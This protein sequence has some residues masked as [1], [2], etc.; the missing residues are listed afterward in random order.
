MSAWS[1]GEAGLWAAAM[2]Y[3]LVRRYGHWTA[4]RRWAHEEGD[5]DGGPVGNRCCPRG[6]ITTPE[7]TL[8]RVVAALC[9]WRGRLESLAGWFE[10]YPLE[11]ADVGGRRIPW[12]RAARH[13]I[14]QVTD[15]TGCGSG[16]HGH[17]CQALT[18]FLSRRGIAPDTAQGLNDQS[19]GGRFLSWNDPDRA[20][21]EGIAERLALSLR[22]D[23]GTRSAEPTPD[24]PE[25]W[26][27]VREAVPWQEAPD[28]RDPARCCLPG[29][30]PD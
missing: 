25:R 8:A 13:L 20:L 16:R 10:A 15:R 27:A 23:A 22:P 1:R 28:N 6:S 17:R 9:E 14:P 4:G 7:K 12:V 2:S 21:V 18:R 24:H 5:S 26:L 19:I 29:L 11:P 30:A 3:A